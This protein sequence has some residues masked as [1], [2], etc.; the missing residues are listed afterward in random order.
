M[1]KTV[2]KFVGVFCFM[3]L[4][5]INLYP[6]FSQVDLLPSEASSFI[7]AE[8]SKKGLRDLN[9]TCVQSKQWPE[10]HNVLIE[11]GSTEKTTQEIV[12]VWYE[13][14]FIIEALQPLSRYIPG[15]E[16]YPVFE[17][18]ELGFLKMGKLT[19]QIYASD[20][21][22]AI[23]DG[24][25]KTRIERQQFILSRLRHEEINDTKNED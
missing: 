5:T 25:F 21:V 17:I 18:I 23:A 13:S 4:I 9:V 14:A 16:L 1:R 6:I 20:C 8:L 15:L 2:R 19:C 22:K 3:A 11:F 7:K 12:D 10:Y 24:I